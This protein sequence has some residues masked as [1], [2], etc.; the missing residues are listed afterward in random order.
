V[1]SSLAFLPKIYM[2]YSSNYSCYNPC[3]SHISQLDYSNYTWR[4]V[5]I[6]KLLV[7]QFSPL[8]RLLNLLGPNIP[9]SNLSSNTL[10]LRSS[11]N[12]RDQVLHPYRNTGKIIILHILIFTFLTA[13][14]K[15]E[16]SGANGSKHWH[17]L[18]SLNFLLNQTLVCYYHPQIFDL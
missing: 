13:V 5:Q 10:S 3:P 8:S 9:L 1:V 6:T 4:R 18:S 15:T 11:P 7:K 12:F 2:R 17:K 16:G 14:Q